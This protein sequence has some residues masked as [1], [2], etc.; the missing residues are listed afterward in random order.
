MSALVACAQ[1]EVVD[2]HAFF[3]NWF[4]GRADEGA[5]RETEAAFAP[6]MVMIAPDGSILSR[7]EVIAAIAG[8]RGRSADG[9]SIEVDAFSV[10]YEGESAVLIAYRERQFGAGAR[11]PRRST[12]LFTPSA[13]AVNGVVWRHVHETFIA[14]SPGDPSVAP[15]AKE[16]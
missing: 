14:D 11:S 4:T 13:G 2:R 9:F 6:T 1:R 5:M 10:L 15:T 12:A 3:A 8:A 16:T 7:A